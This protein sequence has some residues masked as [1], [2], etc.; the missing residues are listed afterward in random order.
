VG[1]YSW[2]AGLALG[3]V[4]LVA[5]LWRRQRRWVRWQRELKALV[6]KVPAYAQL[7]DLYPFALVVPDGGAASQTEQ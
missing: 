1:Y 4:G 7:L 6:R 2:V 5:V 3:L